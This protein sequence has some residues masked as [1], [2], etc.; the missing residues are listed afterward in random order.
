MTEERM[1]EEDDGREDDDDNG[2]EDDRRAKKWKHREG[3]KRKGTA[4]ACGGKRIK[5]AKRV[6]MGS[7]RK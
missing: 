6:S 5:E 3:E 1:R 7:Q 2:R 4:E